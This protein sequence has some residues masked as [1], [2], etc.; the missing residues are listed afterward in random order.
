M[1][2]LNTLRTRFGVVLSA[3]IAF[4][5][6]AFVFSLKAEM[7]FMGSEPIVAKIDGHNVTYSEYQSEYNKIQQLSGAQ[8]STEAEANMLFAQTWQALFSKFAVIPNIEQIGLEV[9]QDE[10]LAIVR[11]EIATQ[12]MFGAFGDPQTGMY[13]IA[14][15]NNF[16]LSSQGNPQAEAMWASINEQACAE[17]VTTKFAGLVAA[18]AFVNSL[19]VEQ[20]VEAANKSYDGRWISRRYSEVADSLATVTAAEIKSYYDAHKSSY[21][22]LPSRTISYAKFDIKPSAEDQAKI[23]SDARSAAA[24]FAEAKDIRAFIRTNRNGSVA[25]TYL[26]ATQLPAA[27]SAD[28]VAGKMFGPVNNG[29]NW[30]A[31]RVLSTVVASDT[32]SLRHIVLSYSDRA[33][34]DSLLTALRKGGDFAQ[35]AATHSVYAESARNGGDVGAVPF[36]ALASEFSTKL[37][38]AKKG[39]IVE[40]ESGDMI[41]LMQVYEAG[42]RIVHYQ[43]ASLDTPIL[44]S[45]ATRRSTH[46]AAGVFAIAANAT[47]DAEAFK[48]A[49]SESDVVARTANLTSATRTVSAIQGSSEVARWAQRAEVG[50]VSEIFKVDDAYVVAMLTKIDDSEYRAMSEVESTIKRTLQSEKKFEIIKSELKSGASLDA[51][52]KAWGGKVNDFEGV[53]FSQTY[54][55]G[56]GVEPRVIGA[57]TS[58]SATG[59]VSSPVQGNSAL[60]LFEVSKVNDAEEPQNAEAEKVRAEAMAANMVQQTLFSAIEALSDVEDLRGKAL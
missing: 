17:R 47:K 41:Q 5:L 22:R 26:P 7:G 53:N 29:D 18:G 49:A 16:L 60:F 12:T 11:G 15:M 24:E 3:V 27:E 52:A 1:A 6:L 9:T 4:A 13:N 48:S 38:G 23:E 10:R 56:L 59:A 43:V 2:T 35:A 54:V 57:I 46:N 32:L 50:K 55:T 33:L 45:E 37:A 51:Q 44:P 14:A 20:G 42:K 58:T 8:A 36:S 25:D 40:I 19:E 39:D 28:L 34:A 21:K 30:R 31:S